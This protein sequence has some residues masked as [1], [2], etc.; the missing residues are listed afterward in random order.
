LPD[1]DLLPIL[2]NAGPTRDDS[3]NVTGGIIA[4]RDISDIV[5]L[6]QD[7]ELLVRELNHRVKNLFSMLSG[8]IELTARNSTDVGEMAGALTGR[9][10]ALAK[11][12][13]L[14]RPAI[15]PGRAD[16]DVDLEHLLGELLAP[17]LG[18]GAPPCRITGPGVAI[19]V[20]AAASFALVIHELATN[21]AKYGGLSVPEGEIEI[22][23]SEQDGNLA[24]KW[25]ER[26]G[27]A[28]QGEPDHVGFGSKL[29]DVT[30]KRQLS[31]SIKYD[32]EQSGVSVS[33]SVPLHSLKV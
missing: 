16:A 25:C 3:G 7:R 13:E 21:A 4:W 32:W 22:E 6:E 33:I 18:T 26:G 17:H 20:N 30:V 2:C 10:Q 8:M 19:G 29:I 23:W 5:E 1:G 9:V 12:H 15:I 31:G 24:L 11:A 27:L 14:I 28:V